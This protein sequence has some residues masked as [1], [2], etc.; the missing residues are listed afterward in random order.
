MTVLDSSALIALLSG[1]AA[2]AEVQDLLHRRPP[3]A[4]SAVNLEEVIDHLVRIKGASPEIA[5]DAIDLLIVSGLEVHAFWLPN[6]RQ[7]A[8]L[9]AAHYD[10]RKS[11]ISLADCACLATA[12]A[13][14]T[15]L[16]TSDPA[17]AAAAR[18][19]GV[20]VIALPNSV[21]VRP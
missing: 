1:E 11:A 3:P 17:L 7:T 13:L 10:R 21:G 18:A 12:I 9:R 2:R 4:I 5:N 16:A 6:S 15:D 14:K 20:P 8:S 19:E